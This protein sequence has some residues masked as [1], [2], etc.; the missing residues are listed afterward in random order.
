MG[1][2]TYTFTLN[3]QKLSTT[4]ADKLEAE[5]HGDRLPFD[6]YVAK[7]E[8][9]LDDYHREMY[10]R[11]QPLTADEIIRVL[12]TEPEGADVLQL[13]APFDWLRDFYEIG[14]NGGHEQIWFDYGFE[15]VYEVDNK[16]ECWVYMNQLSNFESYNGLEDDFEKHSFYSS[17]DTGNFHIYE[18]STYKD[19]IRY[20]L[21]I[22]RK[23]WQDGPNSEYMS[24]YTP[25]ELALATDIV[26]DDRLEKQADDELQDQRDR[27]AKKDSREYIVAA[28]LFFEIKKLQQRVQDYDGKI[29]IWDSV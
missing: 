5:L 15:M 19:A 12:R 6:N 7:V 3:H 16:Y 1:R 23:L 20:M 9:E 18:N 17:D 28:D 8:S 11:N 4:L 2:E 25:Q 24:R 27:C 14:T 21:I 13:N 22:L 10:N 26:K 29:F